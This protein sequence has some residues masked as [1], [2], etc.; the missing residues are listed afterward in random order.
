MWTHVGLYFAE[1]LGLITVYAAL[2]DPDPEFIDRPGQQP[3]TSGNADQGK[4][5]QDEVKRIADRSAIRLWGPNCMGLVDAPSRFIFS[6][7]TTTIWDTQLVPGGVSLIV[8]SGMLSG[9]FLIDIL[10]HGT[11]GGQ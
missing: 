9:A 7:V 8:Q 4:A 2:I 5:I 11:M 3:L 6:T 10:S 1:K